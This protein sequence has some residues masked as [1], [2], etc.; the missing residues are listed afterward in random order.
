MARKDRQPVFDPLDDPRTDYVLIATGI[1][2][3]LFAL[4]Y[5]LLF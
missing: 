5:L 2:A 1:G 4:L 3:T